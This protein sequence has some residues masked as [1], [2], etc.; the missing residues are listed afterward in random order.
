MTKREAAI[1]SAFTGIMMGKFEDLVK[2]AEEKFD[3]TIYSQDFLDNCFKE[4]LRRE[5]A[6]DFFM[7][8]SKLEDD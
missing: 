2:Y 5:A 7:I 6:Y 4:E 8:N 1:I 3:N